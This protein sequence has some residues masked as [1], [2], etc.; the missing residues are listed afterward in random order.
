MFPA[1]QGVSDYYSL[2]TLLTG[3]MLDYNNHYKFQFG[4][5]IQ[6]LNQNNLVN[7]MREHSIDGIYLYRNNNYQGGHMLMNLNTRKKIIC[8]KIKVIPMTMIIKH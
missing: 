2:A 7:D 1:K 4:E 8:G 5:Y 3:R 6:A